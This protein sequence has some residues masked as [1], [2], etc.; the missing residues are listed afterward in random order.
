LPENRNYTNY[1]DMLEKES[2]IPAGERMDFVV[3]VT[4]NFA[5]FDPAI[6]ALDKGFHV[7]IE[8]P[9]TL[10]L[11]EAKRLKEKVDETGLLLCLTHTYTGY[12]MVKQAKKLIQDN[13]LGKIR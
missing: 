10:S 3:I 7:V 8:K 12:P 5:H 9:I 2:K 13:T 4:P 1:Q 11:D 6:M